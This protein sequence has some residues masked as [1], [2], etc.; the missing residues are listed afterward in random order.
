MSLP[1]P[2]LFLL[3]KIKHV[4][5]EAPYAKIATSRWVV[6]LLR[7]SQIATLLR[8][9]HTGYACLPKARRKRSTGVCSHD[10][11]GERSTDDR[12]NLLPENNKNDETQVLDDS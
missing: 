12:M 10:E 5:H 6:F 11:N 7:C 3:R 8:V 2:F 9:L 4:Q 1:C